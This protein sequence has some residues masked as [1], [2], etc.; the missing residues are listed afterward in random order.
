MNIILALFLILS[1][2]LYSQL[3]FAD[4]IDNIRPS[5]CQID[6]SSR[7]Q[8]LILPDVS[9]ERLSFL[10]ATSSKTSFS[11]NLRNCPFFYLNQNGERKNLVFLRFTGDINQHGRIE[12]INTSPNASRGISIQLSQ[13]GRP[14]DL[15]NDDAMPTVDLRNT[16][17]A[18]SFNMQA[19][20][21]T[22]SVQIRPGDFFSRVSFE[23]NYK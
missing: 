5:S 9:S 22:E 2:G 10:N 21:F 4:K 18:V 14:I 17:H 7:H 16:E 12:N 20:Y 13:E 8:T 11:I 19:E 23:I 3:S 15:N 6:E 1:V